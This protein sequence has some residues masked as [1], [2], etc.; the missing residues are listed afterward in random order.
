MDIL[1]VD[2]AKESV[3]VALTED[4]RHYQTEQFANN[5]QGHEALLAWLGRQSSGQVHLCL[6]ATG[7]YGEALAHVCYQRGYLVSILNPLQIH[8][9]GQSKLR[10][11]KNDHLDAK[12]I[13]DFAFTQHP[14][15]WQPSTQ[16]QRESKELSR[17]IGTLKEDR[18]RKRNQLA[19][20]I[21]S[22]RLKRS[23]E[24]TI[25]F[26]DK[27]IALL[28]EELAQ[29]QRANP[30]TS[31]DLDLLLSVPGIGLRTASRFLAEVDVS[32][33][34]QAS[35]LAAYAGLIPSEHASGT[36]VRKKPHLSK[37]GNRRLRTLFFMPALSAHRFNPLIANL[38]TRLKAKAK[39]PMCII[40]AVMRKLLHLAY[41][42]LKTRKPFDPH[43]AHS[44]PV[45]G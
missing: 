1:G 31:E 34:A 27:E 5:R 33:F 26:L 36:S 14:Q 25:R 42:V 8:A 28:E 2:I 24:K 6:E 23:I 16:R 7:R 18:Q 40:G 43:H 22:A 13:A 30:K 10:R 29:M 45:G 17:H 41:G 11:H 37:V 19:S 4:N 9:Y 3:E 21:T 35:H 44:I 15:L 38:R 12:L 32:R 20:G 39:A